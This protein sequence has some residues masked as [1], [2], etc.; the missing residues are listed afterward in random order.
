[1]LIFKECKRNNLCVD[2]DN[3]K[4]VL[5]GK[6]SSDCPK[7][8]CDRPNEEQYKCDSCRFIDGYIDEMRKAIL[9]EDS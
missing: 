6:K 5:K 8:R 1:M 4:C 3:D 9:G 2:C 7:Y